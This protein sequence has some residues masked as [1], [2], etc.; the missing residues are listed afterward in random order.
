M[1]GG[2]LQ[3]LCLGLVVLLLGGCTKPEPAQPEARIPAVPGYAAKADSYHEKGRAIYNFH[4]YYCHGYSGDAKTLAASYLK[5]PPRDFTKAD[6]DELTRERMLKSVREGRPGTAMAAYGHRLSEDEIEAVVDFIRR[7]FM[8]QGLENTRYHTPGNGWGDHE[9]YV[10]AYPFAL[11]ELALDTPDEALDDA[12]RAGKR[13][14]LSSCISCHDRARVSDEGPAWEAVA[15]SYPRHHGMQP[16]PAELDA[17]GGASVYARHDIAPAISGLG[18]E[19]RA[20]EA[21]YQQNCA[22]CH[23][24]D[25]TGRNWIG[26][27]LEPHPRDLTDPD[28]WRRVDDKYLLQVIRQGLPGTSMPAWREVLSD[29]QQRQILAYLRAAFGSAQRV[30]DD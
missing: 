3:I 26:S 23:A 21:L 7:E 20:G 15:V 8:E 18:V 12:Q 24:A 22:F 28:F 10:A 25:G 19:A 6:A 16:P 2:I 11:G 14:F 27:F 17:L 4:C 13:L 9:R 5:P 30:A 1:K 29:T